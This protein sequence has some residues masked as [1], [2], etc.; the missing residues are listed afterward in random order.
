[1]AELQDLHTAL[2]SL[3]ASGKTAKVSFYFVAEDGKLQSGSIAVEQG[4]H[5]HVNFRGLASN[6][7]LTEIAGLQ[8]AKVSSLPAVT[9]DHG[10]HPVPMSV[11]LDKLDP[12]KRPTPAPATAPAPPVASA[13]AAAPAAVAA[14][15]KPAHV[16]YSHLS[17]QADALA[18]L[19]PLFGV[20]AERKMEEFAKLSPP[21]QHPREFLDRCRQHAAM[22]LGPR[23]AEE[24]F[25]AIF[26]KL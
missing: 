6:Q 5:C 13:P 16:F 23:K 20:G 14:P 11:V 10:P 1:M 19:E 22:M 4:Q 9:V 15:A 18:L 12:R 26:D 17:M 8:F 24:L 2:Q 7:A 25:Q 21:M 3:A